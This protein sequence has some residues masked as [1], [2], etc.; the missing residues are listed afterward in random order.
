MWKKPFRPSFLAFSQLH[1]LRHGNIKLWN[2]GGWAQNRT[3]RVGIA[4]FTR[5]ITPPPRASTPTRKST[6]MRGPHD[7]TMVA[8]ILSGRWAHRAEAGAGPEALFSPFRFEGNELATM[9]G[10]HR[11]GRE[12]YLDFTYSPVK[13]PQRRVPRPEDSVQMIQ[14]LRAENAAAPFSST[15]TLDPSSPPPNTTATSHLQPC[16]LNDFAMKTQRTRYPH[17][18][19]K[20]IPGMTLGLFSSN[21]DTTPS[22]KRNPC[23]PHG[24]RFSTGAVQ[25]EHQGM[26]VDAPRV[27]ELDFRNV[28][29]PIHAKRGFVKSNLQ[30]LVGVRGLEEL[31]SNKTHVALARQSLDAAIQNEQHPTARL[32]RTYLNQHQIRGL[33]AGRTTASLEALR[34][35][36]RR[37]PRRFVEAGQGFAH[38]IERERLLRVREQRRDER[39]AFV[40]QTLYSPVKSSAKLFR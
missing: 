31:S 25:S 14:C 30:T 10:G 19:P 20:S 24:K 7:S 9:S 36:S 29:A 28:A 39:M 13:M 16:L 34:K 26:Y 27:G 35:C 33:D 40:D 4:T 37:P 17:P 8:G 5:R 6:C 23:V 18:A 32:H 1:R 38:E 11:H 15:T 21:S 3:Q 2:Y 22:P 12:N